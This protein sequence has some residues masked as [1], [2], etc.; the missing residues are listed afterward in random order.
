MTLHHLFRPQLRRLGHGHLG[1]RP[2]GGDHPGLSVLLRPHSPGH[3][4][5][6]GVDH[7]HPESGFAV[8]ADFHRLLRDEFGL[9]GHN[10][11]AGAA[12]GQLIPG[13][14]PAVGVG[15]LGNHQLLHQM[16]DEGG[17]PGAH[18]P[19]H[20]HID[21][22]AGSGGDV[23]INSLHSQPPHP[24]GG[25]LLPWVYHRVCPGCPE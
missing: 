23:L 24:A 16:L 20:P 4:V 7:P 11:L 2:R 1:V 12:L 6:H 10:G 13:S 3:H 8:G 21:I 22:A 15:D 19:H 25:R 18:R 9:R 14:F 5:A 17:F